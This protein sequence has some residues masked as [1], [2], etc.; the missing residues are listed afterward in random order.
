MAAQVELSIH[1]QEICFITNL[2]EEDRRIIYPPAV[3]ALTITATDAPLQRK[4][5]QEAD[6]STE[7][8]IF[9][10]LLQSLIDTETHTLL[11]L[12]WPQRRNPLNLTEPKLQ[13]GATAVS[14]GCTPLQAQ[15]GHAANKCVTLL[16]F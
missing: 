8:L 6:F 15:R 5:E 12:A 16:C 7:R 4:W 13:R 2:K 9:S 11:P 1:P 10:E 14:F 3:A